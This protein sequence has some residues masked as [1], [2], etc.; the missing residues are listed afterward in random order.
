MSFIKSSCLYVRAHG[1]T[2]L[3]LDGFSLNFVFEYFSKICLQ[4]SSFIKIW[5]EYRVLY[6]EIDIHFWSYIDQFFLEWE[7]FHTNFVAKNQNAHFVS[8]N[9]PPSH[10][11]HVVYKIMWKNIVKPDMLHIT[12]WRMRIVC[13]IIMATNTRLEYV[14]LIAIPLQQWL[15][16]RYSLLR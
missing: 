14:I 7:M 10:E 15:H 13:W 4:N 11:N 8:N 16:D 9:F 6:V 3:Q 1:R 12:I 2:R 5:Q